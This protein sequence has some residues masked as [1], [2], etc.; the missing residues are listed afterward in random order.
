VQKNALKYRCNDIPCIVTLCK[1][2]KWLSP[3]EYFLPKYNTR[4]NKTLHWVIIENHG[5]GGASMKNKRKYSSIYLLLILTRN[6]LFL[7]KL[8]VSKKIY[9]WIIFLFFFYI[10]NIHI[11]VIK[12]SQPKRG[13]YN[14]ILT[15]CDKNLFNFIY[16]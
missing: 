3:V 16:V 15:V 5:G 2:E 12:H 9:F 6:I 14:A 8:Y 7:I 13:Q 4:K 11:Y 10:Y 1:H